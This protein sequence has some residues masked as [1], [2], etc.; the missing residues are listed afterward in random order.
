MAFGNFKI[1]ETKEE[2][3]EL[4]DEEYYTVEKQCSS[5]F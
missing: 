2:D 3:I 5:K 4:S 1:F